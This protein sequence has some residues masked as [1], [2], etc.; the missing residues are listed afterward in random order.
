M[1]TGGGSCAAIKNMHATRQTGFAI[2]CFICSTPNLDLKTTAEA[3]C[4]LHV[5][6]SRLCRLQKWTR[7]CA[8]PQRRVGE[9]EPEDGRKAFA[10]Q[11][12]HHSAGRKRPVP[13]RLPV[14][15]RNRCEDRKPSRVAP[16]N[17]AWT[18]GDREDRRLDQP[19]PQAGMRSRGDRIFRARRLRP[20]RCHDPRRAP[21]NSLVKQAPR[22]RTAWSSDR[23]RTTLLPARIERCRCAQ[24]SRPDSCSHE[25]WRHL[26]IREAI[27]ADGG[28]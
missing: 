10:V 7:P 6:S 9:I 15:R 4:I 18:L 5:T 25:A 20:R 21:R 1:T 12:E 13:K 19:L 14:R 3:C 16:C 26:Q 17:S 28:P 22:R 27:A 23:G 11:P 2:D 8:W 24:R